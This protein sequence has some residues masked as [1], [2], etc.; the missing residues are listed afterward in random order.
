[1]PHEKRPRWPWSEA[2]FI[3]LRHILDAAAQIRSF[4]AQRSRESLRV[5][6]IATL[7]L[8]KAVEIIGEAASVLDASVREAVPDVPWPKI[9]AMRH[10]LVHAYFDIDLEIVWATCTKAVPQL[11]RQLH[12]FINRWAPPDPAQDRG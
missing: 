2:D 4:V 10:R 3:R 12:E 11:E 5:D 6:D 1:M 9:I 7:G 8:V